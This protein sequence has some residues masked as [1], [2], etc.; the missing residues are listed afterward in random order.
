L[1]RR[2]GPQSLVLGP[3]FARRHTIDDV[4]ARLGIHAKDKGPVSKD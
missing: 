3:W 2:I 1:K 4:Q